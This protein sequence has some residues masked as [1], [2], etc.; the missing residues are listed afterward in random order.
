M[1]PAQVTTL[2]FTGGSI[3]IRA[4]RRSFQQ[5]FPASRMVVGD[6][7][8]SVARGLGLSASR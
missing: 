3:G 7:F 5:A 8:A 4:L 6:P 2:Y 1:K